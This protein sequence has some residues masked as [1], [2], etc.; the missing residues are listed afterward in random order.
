MRSAS[1]LFFAALGAAL[2]FADATGFFTPFGPAAVAHPRFFSP[3]HGRD[4]PE[5]LLDTVSWFVRWVVFT[6]AHTL[7]PET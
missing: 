2:S 6:L 3:G 4:R 1:A 5:S 7:S